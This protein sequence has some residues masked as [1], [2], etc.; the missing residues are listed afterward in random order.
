[1]RRYQHALQTA[2]WDGYFF[3][4][5]RTADRIMLWRYDSQDYGWDLFQTPESAVEFIGY[6]ANG[7]A[8]RENESN[9]LVSVEPHLAWLR[10]LKRELTVRRNRCVGA[11]NRALEAS[12]QLL[13]LQRS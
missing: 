1:M 4:D 13:A 3:K 10:K 5:K 12:V 7:L 9:W 11:R 6:R 8:W 2:F